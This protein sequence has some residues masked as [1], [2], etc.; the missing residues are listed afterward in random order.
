MNYPAIPPESVEGRK[1]FLSRVLGAGSYLAPET[2]QA[3]EKAANRQPDE[4]P[5]SPFNESAMEG[6]MEM[7]KKSLVMMIPQTVIMGWIN[8]FFTGFVISAYRPL[9]QRACRFRSRSAS[10]SCSSATLIRRT[11]MSRGCRR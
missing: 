1:S 7:A 9:T 11:S 2:K 3:A 8:F 10:K 6:M 5:E 4:M